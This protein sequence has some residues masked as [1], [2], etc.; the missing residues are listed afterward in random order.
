MRKSLASKAL[1]QLLRYAILNGSS[2]MCRQ[3]LS[4]IKNISKP[5][6]FLNQMMFL[7]LENVEKDCAKA[8]SW[9]I[10]RTFYLQ[11]R[12]LMKELID[13][14]PSIRCQCSKRLKLSA[15]STDVFIVVELGTDCPQLPKQFCQLPII[16][17]RK[18]DTLSSEG[19]TVYSKSI[20]AS[21]SLHLP[22]N[23]KVSSV[24]AKKLF[25]K[26][27][28]LTLICK[29][30]RKSEVFKNWTP[31]F[32]LD[33]PC[34]QLY[35]SVKGY[36]PIGEDHFPN[37][38]CGLP[39]EILQGTPSL[40]ANLKV[41]DKIGTDNY[42]M[43]TLGG[44]VKVRGDVC[45]LTC[46]HV[47]LSA[48]DL[49]SDNISLDD[50]AGVIVKCYTTGSITGQG[51]M[52]SYECGKIREIAFEMDN[53]RETSIDAALITLRDRCQIDENNYISNINNQPFTINDLGK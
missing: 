50:D 25:T 9:F 26:H 32:I 8:I 37:E 19:S 3:I 35:C 46:L 23:T 7:A 49:A 34:V 28:K 36:I 38:L 5:E 41:G 22:E 40:M 11:Y 16:S 44:F 24:E 15:C 43:G 51:Q 14:W 20:T 52:T 47:F 13:I 1:E 39:T 48:E 29:S 31:D 27:S 30:F 6:P 45:F 2:L 4:F 18:D 10:T 53:E 12:S 17:I 33:V 21:G 42:K